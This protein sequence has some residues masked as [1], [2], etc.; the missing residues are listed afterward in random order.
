MSSADEKWMRQALLLA[1]EAEAK[2]EVPV[3]AVV[4]WNDNIIGRGYNQPISTCDPTAHAEIVALRDAAK[5][6]GNYR[7]VDATLYVTLEPC[8]MCAGALVHSR[9][10][11][12]VFA[13]NEPKAGVI[14]SN[15]QLLNA[16][17]FNHH[18]E[19]VGGVLK[20]E[21]AEILSRFF[22]ARRK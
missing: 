9:I 2:E 16:S 17:C 6:I 12:L 1:E 8:A 13:T 7:L 10:R 21:C 4:V 15:V 5:N 11:R 20:K 18:V 19:I 14:T 3:G 22:A